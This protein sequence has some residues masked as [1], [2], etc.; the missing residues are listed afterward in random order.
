MAT[1]RPA[2]PPNDLPIRP[3]ALVTGG[4]RRLGAVIAQMLARHGW[5]IALHY[6]QSAAEAETLVQSLNAEGHAAIGCQLSLDASLTP[7]RADQFL[8]DIEDRLGPVTLIVNN[9]SQFEFDLADSATPDS[10]RGHHETNLIA[11]VTLTQALYRRCTRFERQ[12]VV[13]NQL[14]QKLDNPNPDFFSYTLSKAGL[15]WATRLMAQALA[16][17]LRVVGVSPG[18]TLPSADQTPEE[19]QVTHRQTPLGRSSTAE[20]VA[21]AVVWLA[22]APAVTGT[23]LLVDGG[24]HLQPAARDVMFSTRPAL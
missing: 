22:S 20:D 13:I 8:D 4:G 23:H 18:I 12:G 5:G 3:I 16:P 2:V 21:Q 24:Q 10:M 11:P 14:D 17:T 6:R 9:A 15:L 7:A 1:P 19:F